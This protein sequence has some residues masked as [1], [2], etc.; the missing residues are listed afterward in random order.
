M[1]FDRWILPDY[2]GPCKPARTQFLRPNE[3]E[4]SLGQEDKPNHHPYQHHGEIAAHS[5]LLW[6]RGL[7]GPH[8]NTREGPTPAKIL[9]RAY[10][11]RILRR[12]P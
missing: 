7:I 4:N 8:L 12:M 2:S 1:P 9:Q 11:N 5:F 6:P 10:C 3:F